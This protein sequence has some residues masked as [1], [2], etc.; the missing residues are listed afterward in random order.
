MSKVVAVGELTRYLANLIS[1]DRALRNLA[2]KGEISNFKQYASGHCYFNLKDTQ[3]II[4]CVMFRSSA[5]RLRFRPE[6]GMAVIAAGSVNVYIEGGRYQLYVNDM[7]PDG[8]GDLAMAFEQLKARLSQDGLFDQEHKKPLPIYPATIGIVTSSSG[9]VLRDIYRVSKRRFPGIRLVL[10]P[11]QVQGAGAA[12]QIAQAVDFFNV[13]YPVDVLIVGRGGGSLEDLWA[14]NEEVVVRAIY[15]SA[16]PVISAVGHETDFTL[17]D[18]V[19]DERAATPS[20][21]AEMAVRD[22]QEIAA[23]LLSLQTRLRNSAVQQLDIRRKGI[24]HLLTRPVMENPHLM[25]EQRMERLDNLAARLGQSGSQQLKQQVQHLTHLMDKLELM[26]PMNTL[27]RGYGMVRSKDNRVIATIQ[28]VQA[29][30]R[31]QVELQDGIIHAQAVA[32]EEV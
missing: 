23:Q 31:I 2:V 21:A 20:Q 7:L 30:D 11:V 27:R 24:V 3:G 14:F 17:A 16:I 13:H 18:F 9:A 32:L 26:N 8:V 29:G 10:K 12:E 22:G 15:N 28:E 19:A 1:G 25:L 6:D 5:S 4:P